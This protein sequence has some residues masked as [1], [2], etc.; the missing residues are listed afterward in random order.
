[1]KVS[2]LSVL[3]V[4]LLFFPMISGG[5]VDPVLLNAKLDM[6]PSQTY[7][8]HAPMVITSNADFSSEGWSGD[9]SQGNPYMI[10]WLSFTS[11]INEACIQISDTT[12]WFRIMNCSFE[13]TSFANPIVLNNVENGEIMYSSVSGQSLGILLNNANDVT[14][15]YLDLPSTYV[16]M[17]QSDVCYVRNCIITAAPGDGI[18]LNNCNWIGMYDNIISDCAASGISILDSWDCTVRYCTVANNSMYQIEISGDSER[19]VIYQNELSSPPGD[20]ANDNGNNNSWSSGTMGNWWSDYD[21]SGYYYISGSAGSVDYYPSGPSSGTTTTG[22]QTNPTAPVVSPGA[23][24]VEVWEP[25]DINTRI[26]FVLS[27]VLSYCAIIIIAFMIR[28]R[29]RGTQ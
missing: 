20:M 29:K 12:A 10:E 18:Y 8:P 25:M 3:F 28:V 9:G 17:E 1:M 26:V 14:L 21:G 19:N 5:I 13:P 23:A 4:S 24:I 6:T 15:S 2:I 16:I 27:V 11:A 22:S 7:T